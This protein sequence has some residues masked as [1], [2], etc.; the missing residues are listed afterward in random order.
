MEEAPIVAYEKMMKEE[1]GNLKKPD[2]LNKYLRMHSQNSQASKSTSYNY[3][4]KK[5]LHPNEKAVRKRNVS[6]RNPNHRNSNRSD[7]FGVF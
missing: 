5:N 2:D 1:S 3:F 6:M 4:L 7:S